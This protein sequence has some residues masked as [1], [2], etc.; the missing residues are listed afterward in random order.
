MTLSSVWTSVKTE[1]SHFA[2]LAKANPVV[3]AGIGV[4]AIVVAKLSGDALKKKFR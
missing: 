3:A 1:A 4:G 2:S